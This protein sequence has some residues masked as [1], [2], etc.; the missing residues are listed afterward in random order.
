[1]PR[2]VR[3]MVHNISDNTNDY[4][5]VSFIARCLKYTLLNNSAKDDWLVD[6]IWKPNDV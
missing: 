4:R 3:N 6:Y 5:V 2:K 1:M